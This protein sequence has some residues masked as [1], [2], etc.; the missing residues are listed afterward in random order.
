MVLHAHG[1]DVP[2]ILFHSGSVA[3]GLAVPLAFHCPSAFPHRN[4]T[5]DIPPRKECGYAVDFRAEH[6]VRHMHN[7]AFTRSAPLPLLS[8]LLLPSHPGFLPASSSARSTFT[9]LPRYRDGIVAGALHPRTFATFDCLVR[10]SPNLKYP[11]AGPVSHFSTL[12]FHKKA[13]SYP[14]ICLATCGPCTD[15]CCPCA[16]GTRCVIGWPFEAFQA[17]AGDEHCCSDG[18]RPSHFFLTW[19]SFFFAHPRSQV[20]MLRVHSRCD[21]WSDRC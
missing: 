5:D 16:R 7:I 4:L 13:A 19:H 2:V 21:C 20:T 9:H 12:F 18:P 17:R 6:E 11:C 15:A 1:M 3:S 10:E 14:H 8:P